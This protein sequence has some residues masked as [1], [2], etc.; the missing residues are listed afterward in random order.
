MET[1]GGRRSSASWVARTLPFLSFFLLALSCG[2]GD[3][4]AQWVKK[5]KE[6]DPAA[7]GKAAWELGELRDPRAVEPLIS[8]LKDRDVDVQAEAI[9]ALGKVGTPAVPPL[10][11]CLSER[12][13]RLR[14]NAV[15]A[16]GVIQDQRSVNSLI[17]LLYD[18]DGDVSRAA[19]WALG[20]K[21]RSPS[22]VRPLIGLLRVEDRALRMNAAEALGEMGDA[23][24]VSPLIEALGHPD[25][26]FR[27]RVA[28]ALGGL[29]DKRAVEP[30]IAALDDDY[31][32]VRWNVVWALGEIGDPRAVG[33]LIKAM[34][35]ADSTFQPDIGLAL[36]KITGEGFGLRE[37]EWRTWWEENRAG[38]S[39]GAGFGAGSR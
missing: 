12:E 5:L 11:E 35:H 2:G 21:M 8:T 7:R 28:G 20:K 36:E 25:A 38:K 32:Y 22:A 19:I 24:A 27:Y 10:I 3:P 9:I 4:T 16:L 14:K 15:A 37:A 13:P 18:R 23:R 6:N 39:G 29:R 17:P 31:C 1:P 33:P 30:L 26:H 34:G